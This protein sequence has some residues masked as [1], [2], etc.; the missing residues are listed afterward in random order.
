MTDVGKLPY[1]RLRSRRIYGIELGY[2]DD[3]S[4]RLDGRCLK[5]QEEVV[6]GYIFGTVSPNLCFIPIHSLAS[7]TWTVL[8]SLD[9]ATS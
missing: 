1:L 7:F 5:G 6:F 3:W 4:F 2:C 9:L 8:P